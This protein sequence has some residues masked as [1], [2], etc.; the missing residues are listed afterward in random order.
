MIKGGLGGW[1]G[2]GKVCRLFF[3]GEGGRVMCLGAHGSVHC[4]ASAAGT[5]QGVILWLFFGC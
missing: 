4:G 3:A 2:G 5:G 1:H